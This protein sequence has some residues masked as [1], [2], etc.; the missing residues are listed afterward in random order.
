MKKFRNIFIFTFFILS[1][2]II[3]LSSMNKSYSY[4]AITQVTGTKGNYVLEIFD[5]D[6]EYQISCDTAFKYYGINKYQKRNKNGE[7][8]YF[9]NCK[10]T[11]KEDYELNQPRE[12]A[13]I[14]ARD[15]GKSGIRVRSTNDVKKALDDI[16][17]N[18]KIGT[19]YFE[20]AINE[21]INWDEVR[22]YFDKTYGVVDYRTNYYDYNHKGKF[23]PARYGWLDLESKNTGTIELNTSNIRLTKDELQVT[24]E[25][26]NKL[27]PMLEGNGT[28]YEKVLATYKYII[29][30]TT[31]ITDNGFDNYLDSNTSIYDVFINKKSVCIGYS[32]AFSYI[33]DK[34]GIESYIVDQITK[35]DIETMTF[36]SV[37]TY[38]IVKID[39]KFYKIDIT[40]NIFLTGLSSKELSDSKLKISTSSYNTSGKKTS[41]SFNESKI[42]QY[43]NEAKNKTTTT[44]KKIELTTTKRKTT[45]VTGGTNRTF[46]TTTTTSEKDYK[47]NTTTRKTSKTTTTTSEK[48]QYQTTTTKNQYIRP[49]EDIKTTSTTTKAILKKDKKD[50]STNII[51]IGIGVGVIVLYI[52]YKTLGKNKKRNYDDDITDILTKYRGK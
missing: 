29:T 8:V 30:H 10:Q 18:Y 31:Y 42:N 3:S 48:T 4:G 47:T 27:L 37:H 15:K 26:V 41:Y 2:G 32:I 35:N 44:T 20:F 51:L 25:F 22:N 40:G 50:N 43:L 28:D 39:N 5:A 12:E 1:I 11:T 6:T 13:D 7:P 17:N 52:I 33:M 23:E 46:T 16:Y 34:F 36:S 21:K 38:N 14:R 9:Y 19:F 49:D 45:K 24:E